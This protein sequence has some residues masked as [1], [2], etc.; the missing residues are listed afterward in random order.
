MKHISQVQQAKR[1]GPEGSSRAEDTKRSFLFWPPLTEVQN[2]T[3]RNTVTH[4]SKYQSYCVCEIWYQHSK[5]QLEK[6]VAS[7]AKQVNLLNGN[8][9]KYVLLLPNDERQFN[10]KCT[11]TIWL[12]GGQDIGTV[13]LKEWGAVISPNKINEHRMKDL[14]LFSRRIRNLGPL[15]WPGNF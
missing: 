14:L 12:C 4:K 6:L 13:Y 2:H 5:L 3:K 1:F 9:G 10:V 15:K 7:T 8:G 11:T